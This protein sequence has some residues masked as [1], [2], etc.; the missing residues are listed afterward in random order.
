MPVKYETY[1]GHKLIVLNPDDRF[2]FKFGMEKAKL[3]VANMDAIRAFAGSAAPGPD[4]F[5][6]AVEDQ[7]R[8]QCGA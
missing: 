7:M 5:D 2:P 8:D 4:Q 6:M 1:K 3:I